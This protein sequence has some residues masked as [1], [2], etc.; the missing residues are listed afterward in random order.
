MGLVRMLV[1]WLPSRLRSS[2]EA[3]SRQWKLRCGC[4][5]ERSV[6]EAGGIRWKARGNPRTLLRC[7]ACGKITWQEC[8]RS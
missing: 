4:G 1:E 3:E 2:I 6:W 8:F 7:P 5:A